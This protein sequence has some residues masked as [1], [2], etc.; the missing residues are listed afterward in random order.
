VAGR[1]WKQLAVLEVINSSLQFAAVFTLGFIPFLM[2]LSAVL[3]SGLSRAIV[4]GSGF[5]AQASH[6]VTALFAHSRAAPASLSMFGLG[7]AVLGG[8]AISHMIQTWYAD[9]FRARIHGWKALVRRAEWLAGVFGFVALQVVI[10]RAIEPLSGH[11]AAASAQ[12]LLATAFW[13]WS[14]HC[15]L[16]GQIPWR[17]LFPAGLTTAICCTGLGVYIAYVASPSIVSNEA[18]YGPI[19]VVTTLV[20]AEIGLGVAVQLGA[21]IG[22]A[23]GHGPRTRPGGGGDPEHPGRDRPGGRT[24]VCSMSAVKV[25]ASPCPPSPPANTTP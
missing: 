25:S 3:G 12:F 19:G 20:S 8:S 14:L 15:L 5:S 1:V 22:A 24:N 4:A 17:R 9:I 13:W 7:L 21:V 18:A 10:G 6:D 2:V 16:S 11:I 23:V